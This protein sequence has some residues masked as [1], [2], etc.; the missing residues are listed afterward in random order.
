MNSQYS[1]LIFKCVHGQASQDEIIQL[2]QLIAS[3]QEVK[4]A[5]KSEKV[6]YDLGQNLQAERTKNVIAK[7]WHIRF[8]EVAPVPTIWQRYRNYAIAASVALFIGCIYLLSQDKV[9]NPIAIQ[10]GTDNSVPSESAQPISSNNSIIVSSEQDQVSAPSSNKRQELS[11]SSSVETKVTKSQL[12]N[13]SIVFANIPKYTD[14]VAHFSEMVKTRS[15][16]VVIDPNDRVKNALL[17][18]EKAD[19][20]ECIRL[21]KEY[22]GENK[23]K[24]AYLLSLAYLQSQMFTESMNQVAIYRSSEI[25]DVEAEWITI[26]NKI[27]LGQDASKELKLIVED[28]DHPYFERAKAIIEL[29]K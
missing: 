11:T 8:S 6:L 12:I 17:A 16:G 19:Y 27:S 22:K 4:N 13:P 15:E 9:Q 2:E 7:A 28:Q 26:L 1:T 14:V 20:K 3:N 21:L 18:Y 10:G 5:W 24:V 29:K 23:D 25:Y